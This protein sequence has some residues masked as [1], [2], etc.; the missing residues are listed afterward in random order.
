MVEAC[1]EIRHRRLFGAVRSGVAVTMQATEGLIVSFFAGGISLFVRSPCYM[2]W[3]V[4]QVLFRRV[5][6]PLQHS[7]NFRPTRMARRAEG[8]SHPG[9][10]QRPQSV[11]HR[12]SGIDLSLLLPKVLTVHLNYIY[13]MDFRSSGT[14]ERAD[15]RACNKVNCIS[16][17]GAT[18]C[19]GE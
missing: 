10:I 19:S 15:N 8:Q 18:S 6:R 11:D 4:V 13:F 7:K 14:L 16:T 17:T 5:K 9:S 2:L 1:K 12:L 3:D